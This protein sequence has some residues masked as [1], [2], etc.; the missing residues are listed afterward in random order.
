[1]VAIGRHKYLFDPTWASGHVNNKKYVRK[2]VEHYWMTDPELM[3]CTHLPKNEADQLLPHP[4]SRRQFENLAFFRPPFW[5]TGLS[6]HSANTRVGE[7][8]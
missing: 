3:K 7:R 5:Q 4:I 8:G 1:M 2:F 6:P